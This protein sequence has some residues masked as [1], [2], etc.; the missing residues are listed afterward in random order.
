MLRSGFTCPSLSMAAGAPTL[1][2]R[3]GHWRSRQAPDTGALFRLP[4]I[5]QRQLHVSLAA[6]FVLLQGEGDVH[7]RAVLGE[8]RLA[9]GGPPGDGAEHTPV[10]PQAHLQVAVLEAAR[11]VDDLHPLG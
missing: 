7:G 3:A 5:R 10:L 4:Q 2:A 8:E 9:L 6:E 1:D 11:A